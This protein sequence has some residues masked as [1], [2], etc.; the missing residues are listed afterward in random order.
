[1]SSRQ[2]DVD[3]II[4]KEKMSI[5]KSREYENHLDTSE[6]KWFAVYTKYKREKLVADRLEAMGV[7]HYL[8]L[9]QVTRQ[10]IRK[11]KV[12]ELPLINCHIFVKIT[13]EAYVKILQTP[14]VIRFVK[15]AKNLLAIPQCEIDLLHRVLGNNKEVV[16][17]ETSFVLGDTV[18]V[19][20]GQLTGLK[21]QLIKSEGKNNLLVRL[22]SLGLDLEMYIDKKLL[23]CIHHAAKV[24]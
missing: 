15:I 10:Y 1:M 9:M 14:D 24:E 3:I 16:I 22:D 7:E 19:I 17:N 6:A 8:P 11:K 21:G 13:K 4:I 2:F 18:E 5:N 23:R 20:G 12:L